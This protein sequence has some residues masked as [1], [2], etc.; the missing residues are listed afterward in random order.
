MTDLIALAEKVDAAHDQ[1]EAALRCTY[2]LPLAAIDSD[3]HVG[4]LGLWCDNGLAGIGQV[5]VFTDEF[6]VKQAHGICALVN[7]A[8][9]LSHSLPAI[10]AALRAHAAQKEG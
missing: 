1:I 6:P 8:S 9:A 4:K 5:A 7:N 10:A 2:G 3:T